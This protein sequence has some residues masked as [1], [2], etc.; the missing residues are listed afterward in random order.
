[1]TS[2]LNGEQKEKS[3]FLK[4]RHG[5]F[6]EKVHRAFLSPAWRAGIAALQL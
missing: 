2:L 4:R 1:M 6:Q 3:R 5:T